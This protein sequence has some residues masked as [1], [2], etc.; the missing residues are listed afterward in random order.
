MSLHSFTRQLITLSSIV[1]SGVVVAT[2]AAQAN[3]PIIVNCNSSGQVCDQMAHY[4]FRSESPYWDYALQVTAPATHCSEVKY[5]TTNRQGQRVET[6]FLGPNRSAFL[7][8]GGNWERG[9]HTIQ[10]G[11]IGRQGGCN[12]G[13]LSS[14]GIQVQPAVVPR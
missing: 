11:A 13:T 9:N 3:P 7:P 2:T 1:V 6:E 5:F 10:I 12:V 14:W 8:I 4:N